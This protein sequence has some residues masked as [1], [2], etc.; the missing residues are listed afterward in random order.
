M[1]GDS[2]EREVSVM[3]SKEIMAN[4]DGKKYEIIPVMIKPGDHAEWIRTLMDER[5]DIALSGLHGGIGEDGSVQGL[6]ECLRIPYVGSKVLGS[7]VCMDKSMAKLIMRAKSVPVADD[8]MIGRR[9]TLGDH[10]DAI[11]RMGFPLVVKPNKGGSSIGVRIVRDPA[12]LA[13]AVEFVKSFGDDVMVEKYIEGQEVT[14]GV[15]ETKDGLDVLTVLDIDAAGGDPFYDYNAKYFNE[16]T[17]IEFS[18]QPEFLQ[19][20]IRE[21]AKKT[22]SVLG[23]GGYA[24]V[25]M[26]VSEEQIYVLEMNTLPGL[27]SHSL[28]PKAASGKGI[29]YG[30]FLDRL[31]AFELNG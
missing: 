14:C 22:F 23:C 11:R 29:S 17:R 19:V 7:A 28:F 8:V 24:R 27:T 1:G 13:E 31:I 10:E 2:T 18:G 6:L 9:E 5:P 25:D 3:S 26:I 16:M 30:E 21:I 4:L 12:L 20:M 15:M